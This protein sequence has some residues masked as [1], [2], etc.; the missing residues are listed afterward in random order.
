MNTQS[1]RLDQK[2][3]W[4]HHWELNLV[5]RQ[6]K[7]RS[8]FLEANQKRHECNQR[9]GKAEIFQIKKKKYK[10]APNLTKSH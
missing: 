6:L 8:K 7:G 4:E 5:M 9:F 3:H 10:K 1:D 2:R